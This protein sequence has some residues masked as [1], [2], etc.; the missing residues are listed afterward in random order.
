MHVFFP[1]SKIS[2]REFLYVCVCD[3]RFLTYGA[4]LHVDIE[5]ES[6]RGN[7]W[8]GQNAEKSIPIYLVEN[9]SGEII[10]RYQPLTL[11]HSHTHARSFAVY[12]CVCWNFFSW[13]FFP[14]LF[15]YRHNIYIYCLSGV[16]WNNHACHERKKKYT[17]FP[18]C[19]AFICRFLWLF[20]PSKRIRARFIRS[21][22]L[23]IRTG[24]FVR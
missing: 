16:M 13:F 22:L 6:E 12:V 11:S 7:Y 18:P 23:S 8:T 5:I 19:I 15:M 20:N 2:Q 3:E 14:F 10:Q 1:L 17:F 24:I 9:F 21:F 4:R